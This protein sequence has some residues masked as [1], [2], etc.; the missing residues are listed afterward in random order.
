MSS[1]RRK[2]VKGSVRHFTPAWF[3]VNMGTGAVSIL[4]QNYPYGNET[5]GMRVMSAI[6]FFLN[7]LLFVIFTTTTILRYIAF[8]DIWSLMIRHPVQ[9]LYLG[10][11]P[12]GGATIL[13]VAITLFY[14]TYGFGGTGFLYTIWAFWWLDVA[15]SILCCWALIHVAFVYQ[16]HSLKTM[17]AVWV[18]P[19]VSLIV[20]SST[21]DV[22]ASAMHP[23]SPVHA[24]ITVTFCVFMVSIGL[25][26][27]LMILTI[28]LYRLMVHGPPPGAS[29]I[30][31]F[32]PLGPTGQAGFSFLL[33]G[34]I[35]QKFLPVAGSISP[36]LGSTQIGEIIYGVCVCI[37]FGLWSLSTMWL[38]YALLGVQQVVRQSRFPFKVPFWGLIFP[39]GVYA[40]LTIE[41]YRVFNARFFRVW[42]AIYGAITLALWTAVFL[43]T[44]WMVRYGEIFEAPC[45]E[46]IDMGVTPLCQR[47]N[48]KRNGE[49]VD[50]NG[51]ALDMN[52][53]VSGTSSALKGAPAEG[54]EDAH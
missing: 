27:A 22:I 5:D 52:A 15:V 47:S 48:E 49:L 26:L 34:Q 28:Y 24:L 29:V 1:V 16:D 50:A 2:D 21:G 17:T 7:L 6:F 25:S 18:L 38:I 14:N 53:P 40:N 42:G 12:M 45:L 31:C 10:C 39:N 13:T 37:G 30:S 9:S 51:K 4:F 46:D 44:L 35:F 11:F 41:L 43:R 3:A 20:A 8:P 54:S 32:V 36:F 33:I 23:I 19:V